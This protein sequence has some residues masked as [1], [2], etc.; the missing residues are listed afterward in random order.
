MKKYEIKF[1]AQNHLLYRTIE[2]TVSGFFPLPWGEYEIEATI[3]GTPFS[4][5]IGA[6]YWRLPD[7]AIMGYGEY[8]PWVKFRFT[9][10]LKVVNGRRRDFPGGLRWGWRQGHS[11]WVYLDGKISPCD[12]YIA[13]KLFLKIYN[14]KKMQVKGFE[15]YVCEQGHLQGE[16]L[17]Y[18]S[19]AVMTD[20]RFSRVRETRFSRRKIFNHQFFGDIQILY[21]ENET[22]AVIAP[23]GGSVVS[24]DHLDEPIRLEK[25]ITIF[26][27]P[28]PQGDDID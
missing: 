20:E 15:R 23:D 10:T 4:S 6:W 2:E 5:R 18:V 26:K 9:G 25:G 21:I 13:E 17:T 28:F 11:K 24:P 3:S 27:H 7:F 19:E 8:N 16:Q 12:E 22:W 14:E 1:N